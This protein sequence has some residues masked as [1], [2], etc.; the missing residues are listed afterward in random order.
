MK[1]QMEKQEIENYNLA[2]EENMYSWDEGNVPHIL[3][4]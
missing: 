4:P 2:T 1:Q 3:G